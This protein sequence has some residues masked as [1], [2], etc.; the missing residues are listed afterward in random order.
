[1][2]ALT[3]HV[4]PPTGLRY[5]NLLA[6]ASTGGDSC[7]TGGG[8]LL[9]VANAD[10]ADHTVTLATPQ[11]VSG[12]AVADRVVTVPQGGTVTIPV[13]DLYRDPSTGQAALT[14]D[15]A[16]SLTVAVIRVG[17]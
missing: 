12:L 7:A 10:T 13:L 1:M 2:A 6:A 17:V 9:V 5:D 8:V 11:T 14:Y 4:V 3:T 15:A 16:A